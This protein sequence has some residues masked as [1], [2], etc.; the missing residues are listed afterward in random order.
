MTDHHILQGDVMDGLR[1]LP[2]GCVQCTVTSPPYFNLRNYQVEGQIGLEETPEQF[3][4]KMVEVFHEVKRVTRDDGVLWLNLGDSYSGSMSTKGAVVNKNSM[5]AGTGQDV[6][7]RDK[8]LGIV[9]GYKAKDLM[10]IP[11]RC[12]F[13]LQADGW[14]FRSAMPWI[15]RNCM[16][17][18]TTDRP[19]SA[20]EYIFLMTKSAKYFYDGE[21]IRVPST[22]EEDRPFGCYRTRGYNGKLNI[23]ENAPPQFKKKVKKQDQTGNPTYTGFNERYKARKG[24]TLPERDNKHAATMAALRGH[25]GILKA[26]GTPFCDGQTRNYRNSDPFFE[27]WQGLYSEGGEPLALIVNPQ[28]R[29]ELHFAS[30]P[31]KLAET[32]IKAG[33]SEY[34]CCPKCGAPYRRIVECSGGTTG[35]SW[36]PHSD[37][38][39]TGQIGGMPTEGYSRQ[40]KGWQPG[41]KCGE[42]ERVPCLVLDPF[43]GSGTVAVV[44][45]ELNRSSVGCELNPEYVK[46]IKKRLQSD[47]CLDTGTVKYEFKKV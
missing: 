24:D 33:T 40:F 36:H 27:S 26:D 17:E 1:T 35:K 20:I 5:S 13:A 46:I 45:R 42:K 16:P 3:I 18:S 11:W 37:D 28:A 7:Y 44:A 38:G 6:G 32:F 34:G 30:F 9:N 2:D 12:A 21:A 41:C 22:T 31:D 47:S 39:V 4:Q 10:G 43:M 15:K 25:S 14:Y 23:D 29:S 8:P 19:T